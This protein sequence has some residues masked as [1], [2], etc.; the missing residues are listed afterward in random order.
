[1]VSVADKGI[2]IAP[3]YAQ[4]IF[5][6]FQCLHTRAEYEGT[7]VPALSVAVPEP[8]ASEIEYLTSEPPGSLRFRALPPGE[9]ARAPPLV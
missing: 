4:R 8:V 5:V 3:E 7:A 9:P 2:G 6:I 1:M